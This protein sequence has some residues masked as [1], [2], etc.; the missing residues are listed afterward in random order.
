MGKI[1]IEKF[2]DEKKAIEVLD[3]VHDWLGTVIRDG[4]CDDHCFVCIGA[5]DLADDVWEVLHPE[6]VKDRP[7]EAPKDVK[8]AKC[9]ELMRRV[10]G[11]IVDQLGLVDG[12]RVHEDSEL[13][14]DLG[15]DELD[16]TEIVI[17]VEE[18]FGVAIPEDEAETL[19]TPRKIVEFLI[20]KGC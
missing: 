2:K 13:G 1:L 14:N 11:I 8:S 15:A 10:V 5:S 6:G 3:R 20:S 18:Q 16:R 17:L 7:G 12:S 4:K 9:D 19:T